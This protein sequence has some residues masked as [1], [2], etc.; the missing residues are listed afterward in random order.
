MDD[1]LVLEVVHNRT[2]WQ[3]ASKD[4]SIVSFSPVR[5]EDAELIGIKLDDI[6]RTFIV[7]GTF[8][9]KIQS[10]SPKG[11]SITYELTFKDVGTHET[12]GK[13]Y[14]LVQLKRDVE[15]DA[16]NKESVKAFLETITTVER[17]K[18]LM[19]SIDNP[20]EAFEEKDI[21]LLTA[22]KG[23]GLSTATKLITA[24]EEQKDNSFA[25]VEMAKYGITQLTAQKIIEHCK[26]VDSALEKL[27]KNPYELTSV[28]GM[29]FSKCDA[30]YL[31]DKEDDEEYLN[32]ELRIT[33]F[34]KYLFSQQEMEGN[35][36]ITP[37]QLMG[38]VLEFI[39]NV[40]KGTVGKILSENDEFII[41]NKRITTKT[42]VDLELSLAKEMDRI[43]NGDGNPFDFK[44]AEEIIKRSED[45][46][47]WK[48][49]KEQ[50]RG[51]ETLLESRMAL[52]E[53]YAGTGKST[54]L[55]EVLFILEKNGYSFA[56][57]ALSG[58][59]SANLAKI[60][61]KEGY[62]IHRLLGMGMGKGGGFYYNDKK[63]LPYHIYVVDEFS[64]PDL[65]LI[66]SLLKAIPTGSKVFFTGDSEQLDS[67]G[68]PVM[69]P[70]IES[71]AIP[72]IMLTD[73]HR[74]AKES[75]ITMQSIDI[76]HGEVPKINN[77]IGKQVYGGL[78][79]MEY[80]L[81]NEDSEIN[82]NVAKEF[83]RLIKDNPIQDIQ[84]LCPTRTRGKANCYDLN[85]ICQSI[86]N[87]RRAGE[88][89]IS[90]NVRGEK[91]KYYTFR[92]YDRVIN[93]KNCKEVKF[94]D[95][96]G[97]IP[98]FNG[99]VGVV[100]DI[101]DDCNMIVDFD[102]IGSVIVDKSMLKSIELG[103]TISVHKAQG[104]GVKNVIVAFPYNY[105][106][107]SRQ[108]FY[109]S[110]TRAKSLCIVIAKY[111]TIRRA[112]KI[113]A[114]KKKQTFLKDFVSIIK[115]PNFKELIKKLE[116]KLL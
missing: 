67:I 15:L 60:T 94:S 50:L 112:V 89:E 23:I 101:I 115:R 54:L 88:K 66:L 25:Y 79:D 95:G 13:Q 104:I 92:Q 22:V 107:N 106:M 82:L 73:V 43:L 113:D 59:A 109:T 71:Q 103:Y 28:S 44:G 56:Q 37:K 29:G 80:E 110:I 74:Q 32:S 100:V 90:V 12:Y 48:Y 27:K 1:L 58:S 57:C 55:K 31:H 7:K 21:E 98:V 81:V 4:F 26:S 87:P 102:N 62:T 17:A 114:N 116:S 11:E 68:I 2:M 9:A 63:Q 19:E 93:T 14:E 38:E 77:V 34:L 18:S 97:S 41:A 86:Y 16:N 78:N 83:K 33:E 39:P 42:L 75:A 10:K 46:Q 45:E 85:N 3:S 99:N 5:E 64:M 6:Y 84:I 24:Y 47:G 76:R 70:L 30:I 91:D 105:R 36:W 35:T 51:V 20:I 111:N 40:N 52:I 96:S 108:L 8:P 72:R 53:G 69:K 49:T 65:R 61:G